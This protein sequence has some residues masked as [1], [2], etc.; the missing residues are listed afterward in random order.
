MPLVHRLGERVGNAGAHAY[1][2]RFFDP[3]RRRDLVGGDKANPADVAGQAI[4][5]L[6]DQP[7]GIGTVGDLSPANSSR[8]D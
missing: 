2:R 3:E 7:D 8:F 4:G 5:V 6:R 1:Q